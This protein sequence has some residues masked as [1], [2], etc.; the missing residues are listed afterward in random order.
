MEVVGQ[1]EERIF[2]K[3]HIYSDY[4]TIT[5][6][7]DMSK[8]AEVIICSTKI[9]IWKS[10]QTR[11]KHIQVHFSVLTQYCLKN[12]FRKRIMEI[13]SKIAKKQSELWCQRTIEH[14]KIRD[15]IIERALQRIYKRNL[16]CYIHGRANNSI[17]KKN[18]I[19]KMI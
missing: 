14:C 6:Q 11:S 16:L 13:G 18:I 19:N 5:Y 12:Y 15:D 3:R 7:C 8:V 1:T 4:K 10:S 2:N 9:P 17:L